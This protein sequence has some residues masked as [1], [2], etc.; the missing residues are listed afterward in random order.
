[1]KVGDDYK[2]IG[3]QSS[4]PD[5]KR[6]SPQKRPEPLPFHKKIYEEATPLIEQ[7]LLTEAGFDITSQLD[8]LNGKI[9]AG[10][11]A[12]NPD[13]N[14]L[15]LDRGTIKYGTYTLYSGISRGFPKLLAEDPAT[16]T[17]TEEEVK[18]RKVKREAAKRA[19]PKIGPT[20]DAF[21]TE[22]GYP[23]QWNWSR[24]S[25]PEFFGAP[26]GQSGDPQRPASNPPGT[27]PPSPPGSTYEEEEKPLRQPGGK[28]MTREGYP[29]LG[30]R[31]C[32]KRGY[33][34]VVANGKDQEDDNPVEFRSSSELG[35]DLADA[36]LRGKKEEEW[37]ITR[38]CNVSRKADAKNY[39]GIIGIAS[40]PIKTS[41]VNIDSNGTMTI[42]PRYPES[43]IVT[44]FERPEGEYY[45][46]LNRTKL[47]KVIGEGAADAEIARF[48]E[49]RPKLTAPWVTTGPLA[50][51]FGKSRR[52]IDAAPAMTL[53]MLPATTTAPAASVSV[54]PAQ[55]APDAAAPSTTLGTFPALTPRMT[56]G[57]FPATTTA[58]AV[59]AAPPPA[60][61]EQLLLKNQVEGLTEQMNNMMQ[62]LQQ[63]A[64]NAP[65]R[66][67]VMA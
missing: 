57:T 13:A 66:V 18:A 1:L 34:F 14:P 48:Y 60:V 36:Y 61:T 20:V 51:T 32:G 22:Y 39:R 4:G 41:K 43:Q 40:E 59:S 54:A 24:T 29:I 28:D 53:G 30:A 19:L 42:K 44:R 47:G 15:E 49:E 46:V 9:R 23:S 55:W 38:M 12:A 62:L 17:G 16:F 50:I 5:G 10:N 26:A 2:G 25:F 8:K 33:R 27:N 65:A 58:P 31:R 6:P 3:S 56:F 52:A 63:L 37:D 45:P 21:N 11:L 64:M 7:L 67:P 35:Y